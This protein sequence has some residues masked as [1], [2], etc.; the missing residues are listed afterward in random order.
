MSLATAQNVIE[1][2]FTAEQFGKPEDFNVE[3]AGYV[4]RVLDD[5]ALE[6][7][8]EVGGATYDAAN[9]GG[10]DSEKLNFKRIKNAEMY[11]AG[12]EL[13]RRIEGHERLTKVQGR[14]GDGAETI[15]SR[16]LENSEKFEAQAWAEVARITGTE[17]EWRSSFGYVETGPYVEVGT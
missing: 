3:D 11:L 10:T 5:V 16:A 17:R 14:D 9:A 2:G 15:S 7:R 12:A 13:W 1:L 8:V 6:V 4:T